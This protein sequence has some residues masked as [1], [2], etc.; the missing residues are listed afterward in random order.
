MTSPEARRGGRPLAAPPCCRSAASSSTGRTCPTAPTRSPPSWWPARSPTGW[1]RSTRRSGP[2]GVT[3]IHAGHP[4]TVTLRRETFEALLTDVCTELIAHGRRDVRAGQ[5]A[6]GQHRVDERGRHRPAGPLRLHLRRRAGLLR[7]PAALPR[8]GRRAHPRRR[9]RD[10]RDAGA[11][12]GAGEGRPRR[13]ADPA[14]RARIE[15]D[16]MRRSPEV[17]GFITD[18]TELCRR[19]LV[20]QPGV[21]HARP[22]REVRD[23]RRRRACW[24]SSTAS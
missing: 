23:R 11:R 4:G 18:V 16:A 7:R 5:L 24:S 20:R 13:R 2:Y 14:A 8:R 19:R 1:T 3:P 15:M 9:H 10:A 22:R 17:Y 6:R 21:G 12:P